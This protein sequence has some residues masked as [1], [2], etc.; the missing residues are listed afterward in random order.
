MLYVSVVNFEAAD[1]SNISGVFFHH[2]NKFY[3]SDTT[4]CEIKNIK[5]NIDVRQNM[6]YVYCTVCPVS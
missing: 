4:I 3:L 1:P 2:L 5:R 6:K